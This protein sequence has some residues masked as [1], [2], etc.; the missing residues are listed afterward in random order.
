MNDTNTTSVPKPRSGSILFIFLIDLYSDKAIITIIIN[1]HHVNTKRN[2]H[3]SKTL[4][5]H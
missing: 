2:L 3:H 1:N 5:T 4:Y